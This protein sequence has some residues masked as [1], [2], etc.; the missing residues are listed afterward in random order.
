MAHSK[1]IH[2]LTQEARAAAEAEAIRL[3]PQRQ[4]AEREA[5]FAVAVFN[6]RAKTEWAILAWPTFRAAF[7]AKRYFLTALCPG[8]KQVACLDLRTVSY[9]PDASI[10][11]LIP[12][13]SCQRC[14]PNPPF[15]KITGLWRWPR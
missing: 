12:H 3:A 13:L 4:R 1:S 5:K 9:H 10:N 7:A 14:C 11:C 6:V 15:A 8:C 2:K